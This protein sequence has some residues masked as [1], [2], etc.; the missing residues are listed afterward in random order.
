MNESYSL[1][2]R[3][4]YERYIS[5]STAKEYLDNI[6]ILF[7]KPNVSDKAGGI[8]AKTDENSYPKNVQIFKGDSNNSQFVD[9][10]AA[11]Y[12]LAN[13]L[14]TDYSIDSV[15]RDLNNKVLFLSNKNFSEVVPK[16]E[17]KAIVKEV[18]TE[19]KSENN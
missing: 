15:S 4:L 17:L 6:P 18:L 13:S 7:E 5:E 19:L 9:F 8:F 14:P 16:E 10:N 12:S 1:I 3:P 2:P 11:M